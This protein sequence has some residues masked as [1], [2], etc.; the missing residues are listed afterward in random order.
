MFAAAKA[1]QT[2]LGVEMYHDFARV[3]CLVLSP[4]F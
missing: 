3:L 4:G 1:R 2:A